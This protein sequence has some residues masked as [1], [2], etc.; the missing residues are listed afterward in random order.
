LVLSGDSLTGRYLSELLVGSWRIEWEENEPFLIENLE[1]LPRESENLLVFEPEM[2][3]RDYT[4]EIWGEGK[5]TV[6]IYAENWEVL[7]EVEN[8]FSLSKPLD[9]K[10]FRGSEVWVRAEGVRIEGGMRARRELRSSVSVRLWVNGAP[11][12]RGSP[13]EVEGN[14]QVEALFSRDSP[15]LAPSLRLAFSKL[16]WQKVEFIS[17]GENAGTE[18]LTVG[19][20]LDQWCRLEGWRADVENSVNFLGVRRGRDWVASLGRILPGSRISAEFDAPVRRISLKMRKAVEQSELSLEQLEEKPAGI[21]P[22]PG[23]REER[24]GVVYVYPSNYQVYAWLD[25]S[26]S[27]PKEALD[28]AELEFAVPRNWVEERGGP[29]GIRLY[30]YCGRWEELPTRL[31]GED[32]KEFRFSARSSGFSVYAIVYVG[33]ETVYEGGTS[34]ISGV[35]ADDGVY[36]NI[37]EYVPW[38][39]PENLILFWDQATIPTG[40][41]CISD[42]SGEPFYN[43]FPRGSS[44]YGTTGGSTTHTHAVT[45]SV[46]TVASSTIGNGTTAGTT[47]HTHS[48]A[49]YTVSENSHVP[50]YRTLMVIKYAGG[51]QLIPENAIAI[52][53][54]TPPDGW[55]I[56]TDFYENYIMG[57]PT[58]G[59]IGGSPTHAH[60]VSFTTGPAS[61]TT[62]NNAGTAGTT[63]CSGSHTHTGSGI[64]LENTN[65]PPYITVI[66]ARAN[67]SMPI[68]P[69]M[70]AMFDATPNSAWWSLLSGP[71]G[72]FENRFLRG[73]T[74]YGTIGGR[75]TDNHPTLSITTSTYSADLAKK[76]GAANAAGVGSHSH[77]VTVDF[78]ENTILPPYVD[79]IFAK[80]IGYRMDIRQDL[81]G[82]QAGTSQVLEIKY[83]T[84][85][86]SEPVSLYLYNF[87]TGTWDNV[88]NLQVGGS[89]T[90][91]YLFSFNL[92][93]TSYISSTG[94]VSVRYV[95]PDNDLTQTSLMVDYCRVVVYGPGKP[96]LVSPPDNSATNDNR[97]TFVW[98]DP[99]NDERGF[100]LQIDDSPDFL[101]P[102]YDNANIPENTTSLEIENELP[103]GW[104]YWRV[105]A[106]GAGYENWSAENWRFAVDRTPPTAPAL[107]SPDN[108][109]FLDLSESTVTLSWGA[110]SDALTGVDNYK[111]YIDGSLVAVVDNTV[112]SYQYTF[113]LG[114]HTWAVGAVDYAGNENVSPTRVLTVCTWRALESWDGVVAGVAG[115]VRVENWEGVVQL[116]ASWQTLESWSST[117]NAQV[118]GWQFL[119]GWSGTLGSAV[120]WLQVD[121]WTGTVWGGAGWVAVES[122]QGGVGT[123]ASWWPLEGWEGTVS[124]TVAWWQIDS[125]AGTIQA[126][127][128][129]AEVE[130]WSGGI[131]ATAS[132]LTLEVWAGTVETTA[133]WLQA[134]SWSEEIQTSAFWQPVESWTGTCVTAAGWFQ[135]EVFQACSSVTANW[136]SI[137]SLQATCTGAANWLILESW[138]GVLQTT[139]GWSML[140]SWSGT[141]AGA[142]GWIT[143]GGWTASAGAL[144]SWLEVESFQGTCSSPS[145]WQLMDSWTGGGL[146]TAVWYLL[147]SMAGQLGSQVYWTQVDICLGLVQAAVSWEPLENWGGAISASVG[148]SQVETI[149]GIVA[150]AAQWE[151]LEAWV[152]GVGTIAGWISVEWLSGTIGTSAGWVEVESCTG[153]IQ[154]L[155]SWLNVEGWSNAVGTLVGWQIADSWT[156]ILSSPAG[157]QA[158]DS[159][160]CVA[161]AQAGWLWLE[162]WSGILINAP[163]W[164]SLDQWT[165][166]AYAPSF[167]QE[168]EGWS[169]KRCGAGGVAEG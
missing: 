126:L 165:G 38:P 77:T 45:F 157:W 73:S 147:D 135:I 100:R 103:E 14:I 59:V 74:T 149:G 55:T 36:E 5:G 94:S 46:S 43:R 139:A 83:Y 111:I 28:W 102:V 41:V 11:M 117:L 51:P 58:A 8:V 124:T 50:P 76:A 25:I 81:T 2:S 140:E 101:T 129:W 108:D 115:W 146:T 85:G 66:L 78:V 19:E 141:V 109:V 54:T 23:R 99:D 75:T 30:H 163:Q 60:T 138:S 137:E 112:T 87:S 71:G 12:E 158:V 42:D 47:T 142:A 37:Y 84:A 110:S 44:T 169:G 35:Q 40:W 1:F 61:A 151:F 148:W 21:P 122:W 131:G 29:R 155:V 68:P 132:W 70:I 159:W 120:S 107:L 161:Q 136:I 16:G 67:S 15:A 152:G 64:S 93:G 86:D 79:V 104:Y 56:I 62:A 162:S 13:A 34:G 89:A 52:F 32:E 166:G 80:C 63:V 98:T 164:V 24:N 9:S 168:V 105:A 69:G 7:A 95:Q 26:A 160:T 10:Y 127:A 145:Q 133:S 134:E 20:N 106:T 82:I 3:L 123:L 118:T 91:P 116:Q 156:G 167:W 113:S 119:E 130:G 39:S 72:P 153:G 4:L 22:L 88:G 27:F 6:Y 150:T 53:D 18:N 33:S 144:A 57:A 48:I 17:L 92:T 31:L 154:T 143:L 97:P 49:S 128:G 121:Q 65:D 90:A 96:S 125:W 114:Q